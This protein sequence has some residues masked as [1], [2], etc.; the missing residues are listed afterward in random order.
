MAVANTELGDSAEPCTAAV[1]DPPPPYPSRER[2]RSRASRFSQR[3]QT[4][5]QPQSASADSHAGWDAAVFPQVHII[6]QPIADEHEGGDEGEAAEQNVQ[7]SPTHSRRFVGRPRSF[8]HGSAAS[9]APSLAQ[10]VI[11]MFCTEDHEDE[12][13]GAGAIYL[14]LSSEDEHQR[15]RRQLGRWRRYFRPLICKAYYDSLFHLAVINF[16]YA[17][18]AWIYL[19]VFTV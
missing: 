10:T 17:L 15:S 5:P 19:F 3:T 8:S 12:A 6:T 4:L 7:V 16:P 14:P 13:C 2:R 1:V 18:A 11:S 9:V